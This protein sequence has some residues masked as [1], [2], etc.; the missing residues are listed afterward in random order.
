ML[1][2]RRTTLRLPGPKKTDRKNSVGKQGSALPLRPRAPRLPRGHTGVWA[3]RRSCVGRTSAG[4]RPCAPQRPAQVRPAQRIRR[5]AGDMTRRDALGAFLAEPLDNAVPDAIRLDRCR[6]IAE[7]IH[8]ARDLPPNT[9]WRF[10]EGPALHPARPRNN[11]KLRDPQALTLPSPGRRA[12]NGSMMVTRRSLATP[13]TRPR[14]ATACITNV[15]QTR[16]PNSR[17][18]VP[19]HG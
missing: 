3:R 14:S 5:H 10:D 17:A 19:Q 11:A 6:W 4:T 13:S 2:V 18:L 16:H 12:T 1:T 15:A 9:D 7:P 8:R